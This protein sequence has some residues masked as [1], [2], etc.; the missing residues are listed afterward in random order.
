MTKSVV[1][2]T[3]A[4]AQLAVR[5]DAEL[6]QTQCGQ[7]GYPACRPYADAL[8]RGEADLNQ[9]PPGGDAAIHRLAGLLK[10]PHKPL[11]LAHGTE[12]P[13][14][15]AFIKERLCIG[16][17]LCIQACP[18]DAISGGPRFMHTVI[19][20]RCTGCGL[21]L[22]PCPVDCIVM[23]PLSHS[24]PLWDKEMADAARDRFERRQQRLRS[25]RE[26]ASKL[27]AMS[28]AQVRKSRV[29]QAALERARALRDAGRQS[30]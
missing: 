3:K 18:V 11:N 22:P 9:C 29:I 12:G 27:P 8:A 20:D 2:M 6:P 17:T 24:E 13:R 5:L 30:G 7:C 21:C 10:R 19:G 1:P 23:S 25:V 4:L 26:Q 28:P 14:K 16:C 15:I